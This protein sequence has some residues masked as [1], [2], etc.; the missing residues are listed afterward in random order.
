MSPSH[1]SGISE[2]LRAYYRLPG[3]GLQISGA[4]LPWNGRKFV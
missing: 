2:N 1:E 3:V 4:S